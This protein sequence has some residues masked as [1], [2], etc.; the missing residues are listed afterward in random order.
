ARKRVIR[1]ASEEN[2]FQKKDTP[3]RAELQIARELALQEANSIAR[4]HKPAHPRDIQ[5][6]KGRG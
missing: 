1:I 3:V 4:R 2:W 5:Q 6:T